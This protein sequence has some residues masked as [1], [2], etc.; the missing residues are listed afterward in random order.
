MAAV[1][2][3]GRAWLTSCLI[4]AGLMVALPAG[5]APAQSPVAIGAP[6]EGPVVLNRDVEVRIGPNQDARIVMTMQSGRAVNALGTPRG[7]TWTQIAIGGQPVG[8]VPADSLDPVYVPR[9]V[10][11]APA[12]PK[13]AAPKDAGKG[14]ETPDAPR[15]GTGALVPRAAWEAAAPAPGAGY[16][17]ATRAVRATEIV[18]S[19]KQVAFPIRKGQVVALAALDQGRAELSVPGRARVMA[20]LDGF[21][22]VAS[23]YPLPGVPALPAGPI[24]AIKLGEYASYGEGLRAWAEFTGG[25][26]TQYRDRP[27][28]VW[29]VFAD[30]RAVWTMAIGPFSRLQI[31]TACTTLAQRGRECAVIELETL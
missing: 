2:R 5:P 17:V 12:P 21:L 3:F 23:P 31:D 11:V 9:Q 7:T 8:Y 27:P 24:Y 10:P 14:A 13:A 22:G 18:D 6:L 4:M 25:T 29:P 19:R 26:G 28:M 15:R 20:D 1:G 16:L 30:G